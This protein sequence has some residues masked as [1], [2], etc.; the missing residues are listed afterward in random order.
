MTEPEYSTVRVLASFFYLKPW[1]RHDIRTRARTRT[2]PKTL[3][4]S[5][6]HI[7]LVEKLNDE[8]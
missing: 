3:P 6:H 7:S 5:S 8:R 2:L 4:P 1:R